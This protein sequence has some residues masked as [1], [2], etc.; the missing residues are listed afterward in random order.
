[1]TV[2]TNQTD[3]TNHLYVI[4]GIIPDSGWVNVRGIGEKGTD[5]EGIFREDKFID[6]AAGQQPQALI[7]EVTRHVERWSGNGIGCFIVPAILSE[8]QGTSKNVQSFRSVVVDLDSGDID[9]KV[10]FLCSR[11]GNP[12]AIVCSG[13]DVDGMLKRH[14][15]WTLS[16]HTHD[17]AD[18]VKLRHELALRA[19]GDLQF[20]M[21][22]DSNPFGRAHQPVR[23]AGS[24][25]N[26][27]GRPKPVTL[28][29]TETI[30]DL[31]SLRAAINM[32]PYA[33]GPAPMPLEL[34]DTSFKAPK[35]PMVFSEQVFE[36]G[37]DKNRW[38]QFNTVAGHYI[39]CARRGEISL[40]KAQELTEG[41][42]LTQMIPAWPAEK[43]R[44]EF[45]GLLNKDTAT[46][47]PLLAIKEVKP[48][49][50]VLSDWE[51]HKWAPFGSTGTREFLVDKLIFNSLLQM[52]VAEGGAG[53]S[54]LLLDL[55]LKVAAWEPGSGLTWLGQE[56]KDGGTVVY[57]T[58]E[59]DVN[60]LKIRLGE[61]D[62][63]NL[64][65]IAGKK[66]IVV[67]LAQAGGAFPL[68]EYDP[69]TREAR[70]SRRWKPARDALMAIPD[71]RLF[72][73]D[74]LNSVMHGD[75]NAAVVANEFI[76][77]VNA[78]AH[79]MNI[80]VVASHHVR[81][82]GDE[83]IRNVEDMKE[84][85]RGSS[86]LISGFRAGIGIW[87]CADQDRRLI[88]MDLPMKKKALWKA[89]IIKQ[90]N[91]EYLEGELTLYRTP[92]GLLENVTAQ[93]PYASGNM[94]EHKAWLLLAIQEAAMAGH[95]F[96]NAT[97]NAGS[98]LYKRR[99]ELPPI[100]SR[101]GPNEIAR[102]VEELLLSKQI[103]SCAARGSK[104]K[105]WLDLPT[106]NFARDE[107]GHEMGSGAWA[108]PNW[109]QWRF[110]DELMICTQTKK[111]THHE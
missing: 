99:H 72:I 82:A 97:K 12:T 38:G 33:F 32:A 37:L 92:C 109:N 89:G 83:P 26:K 35:E 55:A 94:N 22:V 3:I 9:A 10:E 59:D 61:I 11:V 93:D 31:G 73:V 88:A 74:T 108:P 65:A 14:L 81:K 58:T 16:E 96:S 70:A 40:E 56:V 103:T 104:E 91:P 67:P 77:E 4:F 51:V 85:V 49:S 43:I 1:M 15:W 36:G 90:N 7:D 5:K 17:V 42:V 30:H 75:E 28:S 24:I 80:P 57:F 63:D 20:G 27:N 6:L 19:G 106:G 64:R 2:S 53:K 23:I 45:T 60:E 84:A 39:R 76:R 98:G 21:G 47:G 87:A 48:D 68:V 46:N 29:L 69:Q 95:P 25:H 54:Y 62:K 111:H 41:W 71:L 105:K 78:L 44:A 8:P 107:A 52:L 102:I 13:G 50:L 101:T 79:P 100:F 34:L 86:A 66:L 110:D 18:M